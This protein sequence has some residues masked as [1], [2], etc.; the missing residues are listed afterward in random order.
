MDWDWRRLLNSPA[1]RNKYIKL[2]LPRAWE[3]LDSSKSLLFG[4]EKE[5][6]FGFPYGNQK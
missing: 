3:P 2:E 4:E 1:D 6:R 5:A